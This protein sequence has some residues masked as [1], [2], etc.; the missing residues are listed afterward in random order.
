MFDFFLFVLGLVVGSFLNVAALRYPSTSIIWTRSRCSYCQQTLSWYELI[1]LM[2]FLLQQGKCRHCHE[3]LTLQYPLVELFSG[4]VFLLTPKFVANPAIWILAILALLL[5][6]LIDLRLTIIPDG[7]N[8]FLILLGLILLADDF[9]N[10]NL[11][12]NR[13]IG[14]VFGLGTYGF[15]SFITKGRGMGMG[16]VKMAGAL[17]F[18]FGWPAII[19]L[20]A[21]AFIV[22]GA[23]ASIMMLFKIKNFRDIVPFG[24]FISLAGIVMIFTGN[25]IMNWYLGFLML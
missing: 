21:I 7:L 11:W 10:F 3:K 18:L 23:F 4:L 15:I 1:P 8:I 24:P 20:T 17:G 16:D 22:G 2:S 19:F 5:I 14:G 9:G 25:Y 12:I 13:I 6:A